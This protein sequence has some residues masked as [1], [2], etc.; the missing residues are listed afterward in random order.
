MAHRDHVTEWAK[1]L[2]ITNNPSLREEDL[3]IEK[4]VFHSPLKNPVLELKMSSMNMAAR[5]Y[6]ECLA[7]KAEGRRDWLFKEEYLPEAPAYFAEK[8]TP[9]DPAVPR[10]VLDA[11][12]NPHLV[13][14][15]IVWKKRPPT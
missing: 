3:G 14:V 7:T 2:G 9:P 10:P 13:G 5:L 4:L 6:I 1:R 12:H 11:F 8:W 15:H